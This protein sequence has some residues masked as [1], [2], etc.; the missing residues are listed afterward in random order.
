MT[1]LVYAE[2]TL[3]TVVC[4]ACVTFWLNRALVQAFT[5]D[6]SKSIVAG[7]LITLCTWLLVTAAIA[8]GGSLAIWDAKPPRLPAIP[9]LALIAIILVNRAKT[10]QR[11]L[12]VTPRHWPVA[13]QTFR[14][15][16]EIAFWGLFAS[17]MA[18]EQVTFEGRNFDVLVG[19]TAPL[20]AFAIVRLNPKP[21][22]VIVWNLLGLLILSNAIVT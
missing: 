20:L 18:P 3:V 14:V 12:D 17:G 9:L 13:M 2:L 16:V 7:V 19:L 5:E 15:G 21:G 10:F 1:H 22:V 4:L 8:Q 6:K 11:L